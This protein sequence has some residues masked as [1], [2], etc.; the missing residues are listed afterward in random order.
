[1]EEMIRPTLI[2]AGLAAGVSAVFLVVA[3]LIGRRQA[4][5]PSRGAIAL[6]I[7]LGTVVGQFAIAWSGVAPLLPKGPIPWPEWSATFWA[8]FGDAHACR[9]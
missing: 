4:L 7:G 6:A 2:G 8:I 9:S 5:P 1:M 3:V